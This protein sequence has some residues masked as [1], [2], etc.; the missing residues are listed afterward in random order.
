MGKDLLQNVVLA[1]DLARAPIS[2][3]KIQT[4][5]WKTANVFVTALLITI[6]CCL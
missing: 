2:A 5:F 6:S 3:S 1:W 4:M